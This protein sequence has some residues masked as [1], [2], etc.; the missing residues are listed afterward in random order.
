MLVLLLL[1]LASVVAGGFYEK[2]YGETISLRLWTNTLSFKFIPTDNSESV[3]FWK[4][5]DPSVPVDRR[6]SV[7]RGY[8]EIKN[9]TQ[10]D[11][12]RYEMIGKNEKVLFSHSLEVTAQYETLELEGGEQLRFTFPLV[13]DHC[14]I[15]FFPTKHEYDTELVRSGTLVFTQSYCTDFEFVKPCGLEMEMQ[16]TCDGHFEVRDQYD[17]VALKVKV[18]WMGEPFNLGHIGTSVGAFL[19]S[20]FCCCCVKRCCCKS[21]K[22]KDADSADAEVAVAHNQYDNEPV[23]LRPG[24]P[25]PR[26]QTYYPP[27]PS[28][29]PTGPLIHN[30]TI[31]NVPPA[32]SEV[33]APAEPAPTFSL[34]SDSGLQFEL[35]GKNFPSAPPLSSESSYDSVYTSNKL[36]F[37]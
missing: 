19:V 7:S 29:A 28:H 24:Q 10:K 32:Y 31:V 37:L 6:R 4:S 12:G 22:K 35:K 21:S 33:S 23:A 8:L 9:L 17:G 36:D 14:N 25:S 11:N 5:D 16:E 26:S 34:L 2:R 30:P 18:D 27:Q 13:K 3:I 20:L 1:L 15:H